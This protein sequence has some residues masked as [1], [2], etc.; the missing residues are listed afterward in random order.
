MTI[1]AWPT[2]LNDRPLVEGWSWEPYLDPDQTDMERG[3]KRLRARPGDDIVRTKFN[4]MFSAA[5]YA[6]F[7][8]FVLSTLNNGTSRFTMRVWDGTQMVDDA[9]VQFASKY[10]PT[11]M[12]P[13]T[14]VSMDL[15]VY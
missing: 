6:T 1:P 5:D 14:Q 4:I 2:G 7:K 8:N 12:V 9:E 13:Q 11:A 3:N 10:Q 15:W